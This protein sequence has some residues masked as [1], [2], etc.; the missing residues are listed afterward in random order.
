MA[1]SDE[2][3]DIMLATRIHKKANH[4]LDEKLKALG[5]ISASAW[6]RRL[7]YVE[8]GIITKDNAHGK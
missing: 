8:L 1:K 3:E 4:L 5:G 7:V 6:L 2:T